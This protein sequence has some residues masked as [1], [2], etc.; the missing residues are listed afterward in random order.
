MSAL[1]L[2]PVWG[3]F[4]LSCPF[5]GFFSTRLRTIR[6][7]LFLGFALLTAGNIGMATLQPGDNANQIG[8]AAVAGI[9]LGAPIILLITGVQLA[10]P[11]N[12]IATGTA[13]ANTSRAIGGT[14]IVAAC[15]AA[16]TNQLATKLPAYI[17][18]AAAL[19]GL[20]MSSITSLVGAMATNDQA[21]LASVPGISP[22]II[23]AS[24]SAAQ[25]AYADSIRLVYIIAA[26]FGIVG[27]ICCVLLGDVKKTMTYRVDAP[28][29]DLQTKHHRDTAEQKA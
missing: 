25:Q 29:E 18:H 9:G 20:P 15:S 14:V 3:M 4:L 6:S 22:N 21:A 23:L 13:V 19:A 8:Y 12:L 1:R 10:I 28:I 24:V 2:L 27:C 5:W 16:F 11:H 17:A 7:P 26:P